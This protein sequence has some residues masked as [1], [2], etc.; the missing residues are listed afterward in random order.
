MRL[1]Y[2]SFLL[3]MAALV[4][5]IALIGARDPRKPGWARSF[6][7]GDVYTP[8]IVVCTVG[9]F[10]TLGRFF[11]YR[12]E[13]PASASHVGLAAAVALAAVAVIALLR[14]RKRLAAFAA[15]AEARGAGSSDDPGRPVEPAGAG[16]R[17]LAA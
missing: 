15:L 9:G 17:R 16:R 14:V 3:S 10:Y 4:F 8:T 1:V 2:A 7:I 6:L 5:S 11:W 13:A 12:S